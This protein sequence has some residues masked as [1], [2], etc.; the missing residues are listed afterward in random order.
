MHTVAVGIAWVV[1]VGFALIGLATV[2]AYLAI[3]WDERC[4]R[5]RSQRIE[6]RLDNLDWVISQQGAARQERDSA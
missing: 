2:V 1:L 4:W 3:W 6:R 5:R